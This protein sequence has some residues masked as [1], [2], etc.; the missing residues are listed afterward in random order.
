MLGLFEWT[1]TTS[2]APRL[3]SR[4]RWGCACSSRRR[5]WAATAKERRELPQIRESIS[6]EVCSRVKVECR[7][8]QKGASCDRE[9]RL[10]G[11]GSELRSGSLNSCGFHIGFRTSLEF[12]LHAAQRPRLSRNPTPLPY[13]PFVRR[14]TTLTS[15]SRGQTV[16]RQRSNCLLQSV[17]CS[18]L[19]L[20]QSAC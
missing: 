1:A 3:R 16:G 20:R 7:N 9:A 14:F 11:V 18:T 5:P 2:C 10:G 15:A 4:H 13:R 8:G 17:Y 12:L 19:A 6:E